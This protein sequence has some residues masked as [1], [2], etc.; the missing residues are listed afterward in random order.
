[1]SRS[2]LSVLA[3]FALAGS[4]AASAAADPRPDVE[5]LVGDDYQEILREGQ[6]SQGALS[7]PYHRGD[8]LRLIAVRQR[9]KNLAREG[10]AL[11]WPN[12]VDQ[13]LGTLADQQI[14]GI[15]QRLQRCGSLQGLLDDPDPFHK[16]TTLP[17]PVFTQP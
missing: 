7:D 5:S 1:M 13:C 14:G 8:A 10:Q 9:G 12:L 17:L 4:L 11:V 15:D 3:G 16:E 2:C 6:F